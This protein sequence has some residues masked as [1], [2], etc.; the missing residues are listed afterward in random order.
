[1]TEDALAR[2]LQGLGFSLD[3][4]EVAFLA[5]HMGQ[6][7]GQGVRRSTLAAALGDWPSLLQDHRCAQQASPEQNASL[8]LECLCRPS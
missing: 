3:P 1:M 6:G 8:G 2:S 5:Q 4:S 7:Q